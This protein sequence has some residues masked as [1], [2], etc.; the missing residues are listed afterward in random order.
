M[1]DLVE[2]MD[3]LIITENNVEL[4]TLLE[5]TRDLS[6]QV[7]GAADPGMAL[8]KMEKVFKII[9]L[10]IPW[11]QNT[12]FYRAFVEK[13]QGG[14]V[15][16]CANYDEVKMAI[17][18]VKQEIDLYIRL[19]INVDEFK[20]VIQRN[21]GFDH[22][23]PTHT[24]SYLPVQTMIQNLSKFNGF[25]P[26]AWALLRELRKVL[27][28]KAGFLVEFDIFNQTDHF[29]KCQ[30]EYL[31]IFSELKKKVKALI[32]INM[33]DVRANRQIH[34]V[35]QSKEAFDKVILEAM[36]SFYRI[37]ILEKNTVTA[38]FYLVMSEGVTP[39]VLEEIKSQITIIYAAFKQVNNARMLA[40]VDE[41]TGLYNMRYLDFALDQEIKRAER[42][43]YPVSVLFLD[44][45]NF[46]NVNDCHGHLVGS[47]LL[48]EISR[49][50]NICLRDVDTVVRYGGDEFVCI[51]P[52]TSEI[53]AYKVAERI[54]QAIS[55]KHFTIDDAKIKMTTCVGISTFPKHARTKKEILSYADKAMYLGKNE[56][57]RT[58]IAFSDNL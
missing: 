50:L 15:V 2:K 41:L 13:N 46:K 40:F 21:L 14:I 45:D 17:Q 29:E 1:V 47:Q 19:P 55:E 37:P 52:Q 30:I 51:L 54:R 10:P 35:S 8:K 31:G 16:G 39:I 22:Q 9:F 18:L 53:D 56:K 4:A 44:I 23:L 6:V 28:F 43:R 58:F 38:V 49:L 26:F 33:G 27:K 12:E 7:E 20:L 57:N 42:Y 25:G 32:E 36:G 34:F 3:I 11:V 5:A 24:S 48:I